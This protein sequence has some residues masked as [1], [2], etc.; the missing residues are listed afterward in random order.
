[1]ILFDQV[2]KKFHIR[3]RSGKKTREMIGF[4]FALKKKYAYICDTLKKGDQN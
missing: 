1:M 4:R 2:A 3:S